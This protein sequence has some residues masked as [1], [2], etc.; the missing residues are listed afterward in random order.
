[1]GGWN[2][3]TQLDRI[4]VLRDL[5]WNEDVSALGGITGRRNI[6]DPRSAWLGGHKDLKRSVTR[7][8]ENAP[9]LQ[10]VDSATARQCGRNAAVSRTGGCHEDNDPRFKEEFSSL[11]PHTSPIQ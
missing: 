4:Y 7:Q 3:H 2:S 6:W 1:M 11:A 9:R 10:V 8:N 5:A